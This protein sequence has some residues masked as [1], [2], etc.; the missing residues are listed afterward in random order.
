MCWAGDSENAPIGNQGC[1]HVLHRGRRFYSKSLL[2][3]AL[4]LE[5][6]QLTSFLANQYKLTDA[7]A[8]KNCAVHYLIHASN[9]FSQ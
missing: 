3:Q 8:H 7:Y 9:D 5:V 2:L 6:R 1:P 4:V